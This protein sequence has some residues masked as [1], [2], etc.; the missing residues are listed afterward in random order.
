MATTIVAAAYLVATIVTPGNGSYDR[1]YPEPSMD[2]CMQ[3]VKNSQSVVIP[4]APHSDSG[5]ITMFC[6]TGPSK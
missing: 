1:I 5:F 6:T 3:A 4:M 2:V